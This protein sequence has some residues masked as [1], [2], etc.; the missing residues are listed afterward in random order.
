MCIRKI[1][2]LLSPS[3][4]LA[5]GHHQRGG[6]FP[7]EPR[8]KRVVEPMT[9]PDNVGACLPDYSFSWVLSGPGRRYVKERGNFGCVSNASACILIEPTRSRW[10]RKPHLRQTQFLPLGLVFVLA[11]RTPARCSSFGA[12]RARDVGLLRCVGEVI[13]VTAVFPLRHAAIVMTAAV[14]VAHAVRVA[15]EERPNPIL[16]AKVDDF[17]SGL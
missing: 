6:L 1:V 7:G 9:D 3:R 2:T 12:G 17:A 16:D 15:D 13:D 11:S 10:P 5:S 4:G 8:L 14:P